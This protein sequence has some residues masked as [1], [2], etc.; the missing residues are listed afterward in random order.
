MP[1]LVKTMGLLVGKTGLAP[2]EQQNSLT[3]V[4]ALHIRTMEETLRSENLARDPEYYG[5]ILAA[6][7][8]AIIAYLSKGFRKPPVEVQM[9]LRKQ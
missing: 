2:A 5:D 1:V 6:S 7:I 4:V 3:A 8:A 9:V